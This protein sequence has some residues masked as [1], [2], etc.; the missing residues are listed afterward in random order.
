[1]NEETKHAL[2]QKYY[3]L[4]EKHRRNHDKIT[5]LHNENMDLIRQMNLIEEENVLF[6]GKSRHG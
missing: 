1:M 2:L 4:K 5:D 3:A 6:L